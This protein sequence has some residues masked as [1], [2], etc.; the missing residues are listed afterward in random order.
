MDYHPTDEQIGICDKMA[1]HDDTD[2]FVG[3][4]RFVF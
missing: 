4:K 2:Y 1:S 3:M